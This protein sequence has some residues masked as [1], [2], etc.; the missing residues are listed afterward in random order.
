MTFSAFR[1]VISHRAA[2]PMVAAQGNSARPSASTSRCA[3]RTSRT[4]GSSAVHAAVSSHDGTAH[5]SQAKRASIRRASSASRPVLSACATS[6]QGPAVGRTIRPFSSL[7]YRT[8]ISRSS[9]TW[10][11]TVAGASGSGRS[12]NGAYPARRSASSPRLLRPVA[13][14][15]TRPRWSCGPCRYASVSELRWRS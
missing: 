13:E 10:S 14:T 11:R 7:T 6:S 4:S 2:R 3:E 9:H 5:P 1:T 8:E 15:R 12:R